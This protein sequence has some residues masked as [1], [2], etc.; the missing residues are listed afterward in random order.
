MMEYEL[1]LEEIRQRNEEKIKI[2]KEKEEIRR[3]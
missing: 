1:K 2:Q 3:I